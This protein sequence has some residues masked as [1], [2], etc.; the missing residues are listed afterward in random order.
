M[1]DNCDQ[2][3]VIVEEKYFDHAGVQK[4]RR[5]LKGKFLGKGGFA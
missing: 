3:G 5:F 4:V 1:T 2:E